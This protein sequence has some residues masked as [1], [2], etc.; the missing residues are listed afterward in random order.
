MG[1]REQ[2]PRKDAVRTRRAILDAADDLLQR[3]PEVS[4]AEI[5]AAAGVG[6]ASVYRHFP[7]RQDI[8]VALLGELVGRVEEFAA[9][10][11][12]PPTMVDLMRA[13]ARE[14]ARS[15]G[16]ISVMRR[17]FV[18]GQLEDLNDR[19][20]ALFAEPLATAQRDGLVRADIALEE[21]PLLLSM[22][23]GALN[24]VTD[25]VNRGE[26]ASRALDFVLQ[27]VLT[28]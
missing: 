13:M 16:L 23:E 14:Q 22:V 24:Q 25:P 1:E 28:G 11:P 27:G 2:V 10:Q 15:L 26:A 4:H 3:D 5:A 8:V 17:D 7:E 20:L 12:E 18:P 21:I 9:A 6:R 19:V